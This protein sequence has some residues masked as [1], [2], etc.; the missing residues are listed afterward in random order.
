MPSHLISKPNSCSRLGSD[1]ELRQH[2]DEVRRHRLAV[3]IRGRIHAMDHPVLLRAGLEQRVLPVQPVA[4]EGDDH[5]LRLPLLHVVGAGVPQLHGARAVALRDHAL[6]VDVVERVVLDVHR[7]A[8][9]LRAHRD[10]VRYCP[11]HQHAVAL[12]AQVPVQAG[13]VV[14]LDDEAMAVAG[15][16][17]RRPPRA[18]RWARACGGSR[19]LPGSGRVSPSAWPWPSAGFCGGHGE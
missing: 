3:G 10:A 15:T 19:V 5:L 8:V 6:E 14:L 9:L 2:R 1:P 12:Q 13:G 17:L 4:V 7:Q 16:A 11:R 18:R